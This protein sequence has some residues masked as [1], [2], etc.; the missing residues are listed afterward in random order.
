VLA[1]RLR[2]R[3]DVRL[4]EGAVLGCAAVAA[5]A[6]GDAL[7]RVG[8]I[9]TAIVVGGDQT[10]DVDQDIGRG[11]LSGERRQRHGAR[12]CPPVRGRKGS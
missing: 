2:D 9:G 10:V 4:V 3:Q 7:A 6:E 5:G 12:V 8:G 1:D 11:G